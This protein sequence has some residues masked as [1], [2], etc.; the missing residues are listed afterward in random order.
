MRIFVSEFLTCG[1]CAEEDL[2]ESLLREGQCML[3]CIL[4]DCLRI[5]D[6]H[7]VTTWD[8]R[9]DQQKLPNDPNL[10]L[11]TSFTQN[12]EEHHFKR[13]TTA[14]DLTYVIAPEFENILAERRM[15]V[16]ECGGRFAGPSLATIELGSDKLRFAEYVRSNALRTIQTELVPLEE[17]SLPFPYP[18]VVKPRDGAGSQNTF[19]LHSD[20]EWKHVAEA[21]ADPSQTGEMICQPFE[22]GTPISIGIIADNNNQPDILPVV[23][24][25]ISEDGRFQYL[26]GLLPM[27]LS[28]QMTRKLQE[29]L[30]QFVAL[31]PEWHGYMS[32][33][34]I[35]PEN[36][37]EPPIFVE[38][39]PRLS[40][41]FIGYRQLT[42]QNLTERILFPR[43]D[44]EP[45]QWG[46]QQI[47][48][49]PD[50]Q[51]Q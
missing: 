34:I 21:I 6:C 17:S 24:Q 36:E 32:I 44:F 43:Q 30:Q 25:R 47:H 27:N 8:H 3:Q 1:A 41:S 31:L 28:E 49:L 37:N 19:L 7:V 11:I 51:I 22:R 45:L 29:H 18:V 13:L 26:G 15:F 40:T 2:P 23:H 5:P 14:C 33:D 20:E 35:L 38:L 16:D 50:G 42:S 46:Q 48:F 39:N 10:E 9:L 4:E 12:E